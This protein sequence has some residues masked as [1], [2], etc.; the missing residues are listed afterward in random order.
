MWKP[1]LCPINSSKNIP[2]TLICINVSVY[3][4]KKKWCM[5]YICWT[6]Y[7]VY[8]L[9]PFSRKRK[10]S[11]FTKKTSCWF[12]YDKRGFYSVSKSRTNQRENLEFKPRFCGY[13]IRQ[14][15]YPTHF[16]PY[17]TDI[18]IE[19]RTQ[20]SPYHAVKSSSMHWSSSPRPTGT[21]RLPPICSIN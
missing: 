15:R 1:K 12:T 13:R 19:K 6:R 5:W 3:W 2:C 11:T 4:R 21:R 9:H 7:G 18:Y 8:L 16:C 10:H 17:T 14:I 20:R